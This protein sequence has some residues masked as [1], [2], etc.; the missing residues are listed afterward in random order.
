MARGKKAEAARAAELGA[1]DGRDS[2]RRGATAFSANAGP[3]GSAPMAGDDD[4]WGDW[5]ADG[6][7]PAEPRRGPAQKKKKKQKKVDPTAMGIP[8]V[9]CPGCDH[10]VFAYRLREVETMF[11][12]KCHNHDLKHSEIIYPRGGSSSSQLAA[13][14]HKADGPSQE[15]HERAGTAVVLEPRVDDGQ[16]KLASQPQAKEP[17]PCRSGHLGTAATAA[18]S[19]AKMLRP[20][21]KV[22][23][24]PRPTPTVPPQGEI[25]AS[26]GHANPDGGLY[27]QARRLKEGLHPAHPMQAGLCDFLE[28]HLRAAEQGRSALMRLFSILGHIQV[29]AEVAWAQVEDTQRELARHIAHQERAQATHDMYPVRAARQQVQHSIVASGYRPLLGHLLAGF[30][31]TEHLHRRVEGGGEEV[32]Q[33]LAV[34][35]SDLRGNPE[36]VSLLENFV[37]G[38]GRPLH[39]PVPQDGVDHPVGC[40]ESGGGGPRRG[41]SPAA[42]PRRSGLRCIPRCK[43][44][45]LDPASSASRQEKVTKKGSRAG[46]RP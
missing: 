45:G 30:V 34:L 10:W 19:K 12:S 42:H 6:P 11:C 14:W 43:P 35:W 15:S 9:R 46:R 36:V 5:S 3:T 7:T 37:P 41:G 4:V 18:V 8:F 28:E 44:G 38:Q 39:I 23:P 16:P 32:E 17:G 25:S 31:D 27:E 29:D 24:Q 40:S 21:Q 2:S 22:R 33:A 26:L 13:P 1:H 20:Q